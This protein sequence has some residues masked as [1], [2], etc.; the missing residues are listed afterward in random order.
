[1][2]ELTAEQ[3]AQRAVDV[4]VIDARQMASAWSE[5]GTRNVPLEDMTSLLQRRELL[6][7]WQTER[8]QEGR[9]VG[10]FYGP[11]KMLYLVGSG[12]FAR[13]YRAVHRE[14]G[15]VFAVKVLRQR[16]S[17]DLSKSEQFLRE[18]SVVI[19]MRHQ[20]IVR[21]HEVKSE[22]GR[23]YMVM[24]FVE[25]QNLRE[26]VK[27]HNKLSVERSLG[28]TT[29]VA[30]GLDYAFQRGITH[31]DLKLSNVMLAARGRAMLADFGLAAYEGK[32]D[33][34]SLANVS[35]A[36]SIDYGALE[37]AT[38]VRKDDKRSDIFFVGGMFYQMLTGISPLPESRD[39]MQRMNVS[40]FQTIKPIIELD[41]TLPHR[42]VTIVQKAMTLA[43]D[44]RYQTPGEMLAELKAAQK[45]LTGDETSTSSNDAGNTAGSA[46]DDTSDVQTEGA[47]YTVM[48][49]ETN[50]KV[51]D[52]LRDRLK[53]LG[54]R[55]LVIGNPERAL[56]RFSFER[57]ADCV[58]FGTSQL[59]TEAL[60]AFNRF[61]TAAETKHVSAILLVDAK[62]MPATKK[63][64]KDEHHVIVSMP[65]K[66]G[67]FRVTLR[68]LVSATATDD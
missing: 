55:V 10:F 56:E 29:D 19:P 26:F 38:G 46:A 4:G 1:M 16:F 66:F 21:I 64:H 23:F 28:I 52:L 48:L 34:D 27:V 60:E 39:R 3:F 37:R 59:G 41:S 65:L 2:S 25:G 35:N 6:T 40:R 24:D 49:V 8:L 47:G 57:A 12:T 44:A 61:A 7:N 42:I 15:E 62:Q 51:Q 43:V 9:R 50:A 14:N 11:Y 63:A 58:L 53:K 13:V 22:R 31:R 33:D 45:T 18:A 54:Y 17:E 32:L 68:E 67:Q 5:L 30:C 20:N 36:R